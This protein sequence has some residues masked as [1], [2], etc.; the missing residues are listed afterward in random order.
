MALYLIS[1]DIDHKHE[2]EYQPLWDLLEKWKAQKVLFSEW[3][4]VAKAGTAT[5]LA[6]AICNA[7][8]LKPKDRLLVQEVGQDAA[9][10]N[11]MIKDDAFQAYLLKARF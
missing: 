4:L 2:D 10:L 8:S 1:Y 7:V 5:K 11:L 9:W 3:I 6:E